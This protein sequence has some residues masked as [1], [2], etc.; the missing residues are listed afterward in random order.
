MCVYIYVCARLRPCMYVRTYV[1]V[2]KFTFDKK[3]DFIHLNLNNGS[4]KAIE[5]FNLK[6]VAGI[7]I[8][9]HKVY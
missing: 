9:E 6:A 4:V 8:S 3:S 2:M 5:N 1:P 7:R